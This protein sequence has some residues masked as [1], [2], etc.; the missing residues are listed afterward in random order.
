MHSAVALGV[1]AAL[2]SFNFAAWAA[3][4]ASDES[5]EPIV[6]TATRMPQSIRRVL[7][8]VSVVA[9]EDIERQGSGTSV[10]D[11][12]RNLPGFEIS[13]NGGP[14]ATS[15]V[16][17]R[18]AESR[19]LLVMIDGVRVDTQ[20]GS[21]G[22]SWEAIPAS[23][24]DYIEVV[25]GPASAIY[26]SDA[27]AGVVQIF[28]RS[29]QGP[30]TLDAGVGV[31]SLG[32][33]S[34]DAQVSGSY[35][36]WSYSVGAAAE[37]SSG[38]NSQTNTVAGTRA[39]DK[40]GYHSSSSSARVG[41]QFNDH[42]KVNASVLSQHVNGRYD[43][44]YSPNT[45]DHAIHDLD[46]VSASWV[47]QWL[48][49]W[50]STV[51]LGQS[52]DRYETRPSSYVTRTEVKNASWA[53]Q[54]TFGDHVLRATLEGREDRLLNSTLTTSPIAGQGTR[55]DGALG[56]GYDGQHGA[57][58]WQTSVREDRDSEF[59]PHITGSAAGGYALNKQWGLRAS[60]G[61]GFRTPTLY[62]RFTDYGQASLRPEESQSRE[63]GLT[64]REGRSTAGVT[65]FNSHVTN[66]I[67]FGDPGVCVDSY[68]CYRNISQARLAG[69]E[70]NG[71]VT[72]SSVNLSGAVSLESPK[73]AQTDRLLAR[74]A[75]QHGS[76]RAETNLAQWTVGVQGQLS[77]KRY[78]DAGNTTP[79]PGYAVWGLDAQRQ[80]ATDWKLIVRVDNINDTEYQTAM[81]YASAPRTVFVGLR[82][83]PGL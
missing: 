79:L 49:A 60:W 31:G 82:W 25:R 30:A 36:A 44:I 28:T 29:G 4:A 63:L 47:A 8:D 40:D 73:N 10:A 26:G 20:S 2:A 71:S 77:G 57:W 9:R 81:N 58:T 45:D 19:H 16:F 14:A 62:Q 32:L 68:G 1:A 33:V 12:L 6:V 54:V 35:G 46:A 59:G 38:F 53:N 48:D 15:S 22:A 21:G 34:T 27:V 5:L 83:T 42:Q 55:R 52:T 11:L 64:Y 39:D 41:Y 23:Q 50:R 18:G 65:V 13:R 17:L 3:D 74:R 43:S 56:L 24:I 80:L 69:V 72:V 67:Q 70:F 7:A 51:A 66:L 76:V 37:R 78:D 61:T 75:R